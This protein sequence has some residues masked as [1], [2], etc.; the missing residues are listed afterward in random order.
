MPMRSLPSICML[1]H[2]IHCEMAT[3]SRTVFC[4]ECWAK[5][6]KTKGIYPYRRAHSDEMDPCMDR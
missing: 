1:G 3:V 2:V 5:S 4:K 6:Q